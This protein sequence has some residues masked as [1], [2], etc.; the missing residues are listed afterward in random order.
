MTYMYFYPFNCGSMPL[1]FTFTQPS[2]HVPWLTH[3]QL[4]AYI[5]LD[6]PVVSIYDRASLPPLHLLPAI[7]GDSFIIANQERPG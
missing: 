4:H 3:Q 7:I 5:I 6:P 2:V 1:V